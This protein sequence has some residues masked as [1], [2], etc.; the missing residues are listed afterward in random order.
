MTIKEKRIENKILANIYMNLILR[1]EMTGN[2]F[3]IE[4]STELM[5]EINIEY[6]IQKI[7]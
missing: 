5:Y 1:L 2:R 6:D 3:V 4:I 7:S